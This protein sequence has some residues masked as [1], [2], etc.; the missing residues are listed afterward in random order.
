M[1][2]SL[3]FYYFSRAKLSG[4]YDAGRPLVRQAAENY[5]KAAA[6]YPKDEELRTGAV[7]AMPGEFFGL[8]ALLQTPFSNY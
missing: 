7:P 8:T 4:N 6:L 1:Y 5:S 2:S 3:G